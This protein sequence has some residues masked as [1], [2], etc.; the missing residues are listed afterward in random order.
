MMQQ[1]AQ[2]T[3][4]APA[5]DVVPEL[6]PRVKQA[7][8]LSGSSFDARLTD[9]IRV[10]LDLIGRY[11]NRILVECEVTG[12]FNHA[13]R[14]ELSCY[15]AVYFAVAP[16]YR[17]AFVSVAWSVDE[18]EPLTGFASPYLDQGFVFLTSEPANVSL[19]WVHCCTN[20]DGLQEPYPIKAVIKAGYKQNELDVW[21]CPDALK[22]AVISLAA[23][24]YE[25]PTDCSD[26]GCSSGS[27]SNGVRLPPTIA[28]LISTYIVRR[29]F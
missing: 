21:L 18:D 6:L 3:Y 23:Y 13:S 4:G 12:R 25:H 14:T 2:L 27:A 28:M 22:Q 11:T 15:P 1:A 19:G 26:C 5:F 24:F 20:G 29:A 16:V 10:A 17:D 9:Y 8:R 7:L